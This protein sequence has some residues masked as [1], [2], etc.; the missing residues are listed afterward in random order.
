MNIMK[1]MNMGNQ[2]NFKEID[3]SIL[4]P[5]AKEELIDFYKFLIMKKAK[6]IYKKN[7]KEI[8][9]KEDLLPKPINKFIPLKRDE[10]YDE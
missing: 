7:H 10:I 6:N 1:G 4:T 5:H 3:L 9:K 2:I 8:I